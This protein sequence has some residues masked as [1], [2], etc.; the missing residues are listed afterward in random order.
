[1]ATHVKKVPKDS[2]SNWNDDIVAAADLIAD[3]QSPGWLPGFLTRQAQRIAPYVHADKHAPSPADHLERM[4]KIQKH[5]DAL[6]RLLDDRTLRY[7]QCVTT[8]SENIATLPAALD[9]VK[10]RLIVDG[11]VVNAQRKKGKESPLIPTHSRKP[12]IIVEGTVFAAAVCL[13][14]WQVVRDTKPG[15]TNALAQEAAA[16]IWRAAGGAGRKN[17]LPAM[18]DATG[19]FHWLIEDAIGAAHVARLGVSMRE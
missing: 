1:M 10:I 2:S 4:A 17:W 5:T 16:A 9:E 14:A 6:L 12:A 11:E 8:A 13:G 7:L 18:K 19:P 15:V 3:G